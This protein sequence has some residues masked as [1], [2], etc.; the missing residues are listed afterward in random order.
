MERYPNIK[1][2]F[3]LGDLHLGVRNNSV[4]WINAHEQFF[5]EWFL[6]K[7]KSMWRPGDCLVQLGDVF[8]SRQ[9]LNLKVMNL[10]IS[11]FHELSKIFVDGVFVIAGNHDVYGRLSTEIN[12]INVLK[13][14]PN[15]HVYIEPE[16]I[17]LGNRSVFLMPWR[18]DHAAEE[19]LLSATSPHDYLFCH[20]DISGMKHNRYADVPHGV[21]YKLLDLFDRVYSGHIH[22][23]QNY[24]KVRMLGSP[25]QLTRADSENPKHFMVADLSTGE[26]VYYEN[27]FSPKFIKIPLRQVLEKTP[28]ELERIFSNNFVDVM[29]A[30]KIS[31]GQLDVITQMITSQRD[32]KFITEAKSAEEAVNA[33]DVL[34]RMDGENFSIVDVMNQY[35][36]AMKESAH[37]KERIKKT[38]G[39]LYTKVTK[40]QENEAE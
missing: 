2:V 1:R 23:S 35:V 17:Q 15:V 10:G 39:A 27:D 33:D 19:E 24:G 32:V 29:I 16:S 26:E 8:D 36:D 28:S 12:S 6:P 31:Q 40:N 30:S 34:F 38:L 3:Y 14:I 25:Y 18:K 21:S 20:T 11:V 5:Y 22:Y 9:S 7:V 37:D 4:E 13:W